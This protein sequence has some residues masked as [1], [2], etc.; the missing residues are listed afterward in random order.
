MSTTLH[1]GDEAQE[2]PAE[3]RER[4]MA[5]ARSVASARGRG[6]AAARGRGA[7]GGG[8]RSGRPRR[9]ELARGAGAARTARDVPRTTGAAR[10]P[11]TDSAMTAT[12][13][14]EFHFGE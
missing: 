9:S 5:A 8:G 1:C 7:A 4:R 11:D 14:H 10:R 2:H 6:R 13:K 12:T 3:I